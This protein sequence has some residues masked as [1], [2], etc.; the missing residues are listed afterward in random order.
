VEVAGR[1]LRQMG[2]F[3]T[4]GADFKAVRKRTQCRAVA[5]LPKIAPP[6]YYDP[7]RQLN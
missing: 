7:E 2:D 1:L 5:F 4:D 3:R 6:H